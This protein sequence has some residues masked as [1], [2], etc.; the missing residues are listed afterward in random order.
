[1][2]PTGKEDIVKAY[3][4]ISKGNEQTTM[5]NNIKFLNQLLE[6]EP[7][8]EES[9]LQAFLKLFCDDVLYWQTEVGEKLRLFHVIAKEA[10]HLEIIKHTFHYLHTFP[11]NLLVKELESVD[12]DGN[13]ALHIAAQGNT[14][15]FVD[16]LEVLRDEN[17]LHFDDIACLCYTFNKAQQSMYEIMDDNP[18]F[19]E[20]VEDYLTKYGV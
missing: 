17:I 7:K 13:T 16:Y 8:P 9:S 1:M 3:V 11:D 6:S 14:A 19:T 20:Y 2:L 4:L 5:E 18:F 15:I 12:E 10:K